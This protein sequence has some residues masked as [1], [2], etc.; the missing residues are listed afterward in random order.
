MACDPPGKGTERLMGCR[1]RVPFLSPGA[2]PRLD[3]SQ[4]AAAEGCDGFDRRASN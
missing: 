4:A 1:G 3:V 2:V